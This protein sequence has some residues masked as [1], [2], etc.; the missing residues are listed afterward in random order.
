MGRH[1]AIH[2]G[3]HRG[4]FGHRFHGDRF[5]PAFIVGGIW[6]PWYSYPY[7]V[8]SGTAYYCQSAGLYYPDVTY[9]PEGWVT[10]APPAMLP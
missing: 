9:C 8:Y 4:A 7:P 1:G 2:G 10:V 3:A 5:G 6:Y